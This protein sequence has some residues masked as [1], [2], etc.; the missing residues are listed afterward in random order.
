MTTNQFNDCRFANA[1]VLNNVTSLLSAFKNK[2]SNSTKSTSAYSI[3]LVYSTADA[4][5][6]RIVNAAQ[7]NQYSV[8]VSLD[9]NEPWITWIGLTT[10]ILMGLFI[11][12]IFLL[13]LLPGIVGLVLVQGNSRFEKEPTKTKKEN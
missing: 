13:I 1:T 9:R 6:I 2:V 10:P 4:D 12:F 7:T 8:I 5:F 3:S 11:F